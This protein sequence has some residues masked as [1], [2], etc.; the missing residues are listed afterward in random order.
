MR[1]VVAAVAILAILASPVGLGAFLPGDAG[2]AYAPSPVGPAPPSP[3][4]FPATGR[5]GGTRG[6]LP[7]VAIVEVYYYAIR[8]DEAIV[9]ANPGPG[10]VDL[11]GWR[12]TDREGTIEFP[13]GSNLPGRTRI[14]ITRNATSYFEDTLTPVAYTY[15]AGN[16]TRMVLV[17]R[18]PQLNN[19]GDEVLLLSPS[20]DL[21][22]AFVYGTSTYSG[23]GWV[24]P[25]AAKVPHGKRAVRA[26]SDGGYRDTD[27]AKDWESPRSYGFGQ[28][29]LP[30]ERFEI[31]GAAVAFLSPDSSLTTLT[32]SLDRATVSIHAGLY[33]LTS[34]GLGESLRAAAARGVDVRIVLEGGPVGGVDVREWDLVHRIAGAGGTVRFLVDDF[35][36]GTMARYR[37]LHAKYAVI[38]SAVT[39]VGS[40]NWG[41]HG[42]PATPRSGNRGW[43][44]AV[45][46]KALA[47]YF[48]DLFR[49]D[50][51]AR[52]RDIVPISAFSPN[53]YKSN[54]TPENRTYPS[55]IPAA[56]TTAP[57]RVTPV[58]APEH[59]L[60]EDALLGLLRSATTTL[61]IEAFYVASTWGS[62]RNPYLEAAIEAARHGVHVRI[63][64]DG[65]WYNVE[66]DD[67][68]D[69]DDTVAYVNGIARREALPLEARVA[70]PNSHGLSKIHNKG[71]LVD[72][73]IAF[74]S[75]LN[76]NRNAAT[77]NR[78]VGLIV[79]G[80]EVVDPFGLG[81]ER[82]WASPARPPGGTV[83]EVLG[84]PL[85]LP[86]LTLLVVNVALL[87]AWR[88]QRRRGG[89]GLSE[90][91]PTL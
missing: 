34:P 45:E 84:S 83:G 17:G 68:V 36:E 19:D 37:F 63:L 39:I 4:L 8:D 2:P 87:W 74:V 50:S 12:L 10:A 51:D 48:E 88:R 35:A 29:D 44:I 47:A 79:E 46:D 60:R 70:D 13:G 28:S 26:T 33:T 80:S 72:G 69:N 58:I 90:D 32:D 75:S 81:F 23:E 11:S 61:D 91:E 52:M 53:L 25:P 78:E 55:P 64:L 62:G 18:I 40:E 7:L 5:G 59:A 24:G 54:E 3:H 14:V 71:V 86:F 77:S 22:D 82:D 20:G 41:E 56:R 6:G 76:W 38:D 1:A 21:V 42:F 66:G 15:G 85:F 57:F 73:R 67:P 49:Q 9:L 65:T 31:A 43:Q 16:G 27:S 89:K 30:F